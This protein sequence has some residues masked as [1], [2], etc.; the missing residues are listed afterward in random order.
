MTFWKNCYS[1][2][3]VTLAAR[4]QAVRGG[5]EDGQALVFALIVVL[6]V[7]LL[8][9]IVLS[10]LNYEMPLASQAVSSE[11]ALAAAEA[12]VQEYSNLMD[13]YQTYYQWVPQANGATDTGADAD[14]PG[15]NNTALG[16]WQAVTPSNPPEYFTYYPDTSEL[17][18]TQTVT[19]PFGGKVLLVVTGRAGTGNGTSYRRVEAAFSPSGVITDVYF[20]NFEQPGA[21]DLDQWENT[22]SGASCQP[23]GSGCTEINS[24]SPPA[25]A[26]HE[27]DEAT[28]TTGCNPAGTICYSPSES[29]ASALCQY[30]A[31]EVNSYIDWYSANVAAI[32]PLAGYPAN[33][34]GAAYSAANPYYG[35]W[36]GTFVDPTDTAL[37]FGVDGNG[38]LNNGNASACNTNYWIGAD[39]FNGPVYSND[40]LTTCG[41]PQFTGDPALQTSVPSTFAF[42]A[43]ATVGWPGAQAPVPNTS[44]AY[45]ATGV[46]S[47]YVSFPWG[48]NPNPWKDCGEAGIPA[49]T[50][51]PNSPH[52]GISS[53]FP[54][55]DASLVNQ[56]QTGIV[57]GC[58]Y[59]GPTAI[60]FSYNTTTQAETM[61][62][63]SPL[64]KNTYQNA[65][66]DA[67]V[68]PTPVTCGAVATTG[69]ADLCGGTACTGTPGAAGSNTQVINGVVQTPTTDATG[70]TGFAQVPINGPEVIIVE[71]VQG[72]GDPN[73]WNL[74]GVAGGC[75]T[76]STAV[77]VSTPLDCLPTAESN[78]TDSGCIDPWVNPDSGAPVTDT[79]T[80]IEGDAIISGAVGAEVTLSAS[81]DVVLARSVAYGCAVN[82]AAPYTGAYQTTLGSCA[83][84][85]HVLGLIAQADIWMAQPVNTTETYCTDDTDLQP[86]SIDWGNM[87][88]NC[89]V[90][91]PV[92]D[93][94]MASL[95]GFFEVEYWR[96]GNGNG[97]TLNFNGSDAVNNSGQ[98]GV[99]S[100]ASLT[101]GYALTL[102]Y[103]SRLVAEAPPD[104]LVATDAVWNVVGWV[105]C[106]NTTPNPYTAGYPTATIPT[107]TTLTNSY[108]PPTTT[109]VP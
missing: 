3:R 38:A 106:G 84:S 70:L 97:G 68:T 89:I 6:M 77:S 43:T 99:F 60:R 50:N 12:G 64:T 2:L 94:A 101:A 108:A 53:Q 71:G 49:F 66:A 1:R 58:V 78:A 65:G 35:P 95:T 8:P 98:F 33:P 48:Y 76:P 102:N 107:C 11:S 15:G 56:V 16:G 27:Y 109:T 88:P 90:H 87:M 10:S 80:C 51:D 36:Y 29:M 20:S 96:E 54:S 62:V 39:T 63:W 93:A 31:T 104:Y 4:V 25:L 5:T 103:D 9:A 57:A 52:L 42:P 47:P 32:Y 105:T 73:Y 7:G 85:T 17:H 69:P 100:G 18:Q 92:V 86:G 44:P 46:G 61:N 45:L 82:V 26:T 74:G 23:S 67:A 21:Q 75:P 13:Q 83:N 37:Q 41:T 91:N 30:D 55:T 22:Y 79:G 59:T 14:M 28:D 40:E 81:N 34:S 72:T 24:G 19:N